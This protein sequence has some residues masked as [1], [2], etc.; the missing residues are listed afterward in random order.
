[1]NN[2]GFAANKVQNEVASSEASALRASSCNVSG[3]CRDTSPAGFME[4]ACL[5]SCLGSD[6]WHHAPSFAA[7]AELL[8]WCSPRHHNRIHKECLYTEFQY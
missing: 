4:F 7:V 1:M 5:D 2:R 3:V 8:V 6:V